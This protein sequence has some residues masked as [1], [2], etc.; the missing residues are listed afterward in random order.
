M[1][2]LGGTTHEDASSINATGCR[3]QTALAFPVS[4]A[5]ELELVKWVVGQHRAAS[6]LRYRGTYGPFHF[7]S[8][9]MW[10]GGCEVPGRASSTITGPVSVRNTR[11]LFCTSQSGSSRES[12]HDP[13]TKTTETTGTLKTVGTDTNMR[14]IRR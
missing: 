13:T 4:C 8:D 6:G 9:L 3:G 10:Q 2:E 12:T 14:T 5:G 11:P 1:L 7:V